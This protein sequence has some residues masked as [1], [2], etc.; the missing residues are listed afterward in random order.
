MEDLSHPRS[1]DPAV[2][3]TDSTDT[4][5]VQTTCPGCHEP[6]A[7]LAETVRVRRELWHLD[8]ALERRPWGSTA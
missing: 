6:V 3:L 5:W 8:C 7:R 1:A 2:A 4:S